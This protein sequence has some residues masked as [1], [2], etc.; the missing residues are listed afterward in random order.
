MCIYSATYSMRE[1]IENT[2]GGWREVL[3]QVWDVHGE[4][5]ERAL[6][7]EEDIFQ[8]ALEILPPK[9]HVFAAFQSFDM[10][11]LKVC[12]LGQDPYINKGEA[13]GLA[14]SVPVGVK[15]PPSLRNVFK[16]ME[17]SYGTWRTSSDLSDWS[18]QG[19]L[20]LNTALTV[21]EGNSGSHAKIWKPFTEMLMRRIGSE[22][23]GVV[24]MLWGN[25][26]QSYRDCIDESKNLVLTH[27]HPSPLSRRPFVGC[28]HFE[29]CNEYLSKQHK[30][31]I[32]WV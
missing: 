6:H 11:D 30:K 26:A 31:T 3:R 22:S 17:R 27:T 21:R 1:Y 12:I 9:E 4:E 7:R 14:F 16:E 25:H 2:R 28:E 18:C 19:V 23:Q 13:H 10:K 20:L 32:Q 24:F 5:I 8:D 15:L 29:K